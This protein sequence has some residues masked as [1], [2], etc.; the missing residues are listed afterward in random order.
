MECCMAARVLLYRLASF[1][2][3]MNGRAITAGLGSNVRVEDVIKKLDL[4]PL[5]GEGGYYRESYRS[6]LRSELKGEGGLSVSRSAGTAIYYLITPEEFS[7]LHRLHFDEIFHF[8]AG[9]PVEMLQIDSNFDH[10]LIEIS[11]NLLNGAQ[12][13][14]VVPAG[15]WQGTRLKSGGK[16]ALLG[17]TMTP[18]FE[19]SDFEL[20][21]LESFA[22][23]LPDIEDLLRKFIR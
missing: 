6:P 20:A 5:P 19:F 17:T 2:R 13:Q 23:R 7:A 15:S 16:W 9:D 1:F 10:R 18:G 21:S 12:P 8:Y 3:A 4:K 22:T 14:I 11:T